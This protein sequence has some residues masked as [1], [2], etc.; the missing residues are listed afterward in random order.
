MKRCPSLMLALLA[1]AAFPAAAAMT[2]SGSNVTVAFGA[3][4]V[5][6]PQPTDSQ[7]DF[8]VTCSRDGGPPNATLTVSIGPSAG[9]GSIPTR[10]MVRAG[11]GD[12]LNYNFFRDASRTAVWGQTSGVDTV[13]RT[14]TVPNKA[15]NTVAVT[16][17]ARITPEQ[18]ARIGSYSDSLV[19]TVSY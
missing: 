2:C 13:S 16:L 8:L 1:G 4:D 18:D 3:Y 12:R 14:I 9:S 17:F 7:S 5:F 15:S 10:Q 19:I 6:N 11:S